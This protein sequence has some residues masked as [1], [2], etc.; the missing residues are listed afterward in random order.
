MG[1]SGFEKNVRE[2]IE[3]EAKPYADEIYTDAIGNLIVLKK[4]NG[5]ENSKKIMYAA[6]TDEIGF[7]V[8]KVGTGLV[9]HI[10]RG[11]DSEMVSA[12]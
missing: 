12:V 10:M 4:G 11:F 8:K 6:H 3:Q 5:G 9:L 2:R 1:V 7:I